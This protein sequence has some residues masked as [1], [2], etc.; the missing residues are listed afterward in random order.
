MFFDVSRKYFTDSL[1]AMVGL[2]LSYGF[3]LVVWVIGEYTGH[4]EPSVTREV[5]FDRRFFQRFLS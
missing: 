2:L 5:V 3:F 1:G 4:V